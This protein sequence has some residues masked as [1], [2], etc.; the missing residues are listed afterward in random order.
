MDHDGPPV[1][2][3]LVVD[4]A[5]D[6]CV[7]TDG[8][9][10]DGAGFHAFPHAIAGRAHEPAPLDSRAEQRILALRVELAALALVDELTGLH[11]RR[12]FVTLADQHLKVAARAA[13]TVPFLCVDVRGMKTINDTYGRDEGD[14]A[15]VEVAAYLRSALRASDLVARVGGDEFCIVMV[16]LGGGGKIDVERMA[17][18]LRP[19]PVRG[20]R[21]YPLA[22]SIDVAWLEPGPTTSVEE[23]I[24]RAGGATGVV[25]DRPPG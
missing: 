16:D 11:N 13:R 8:S 9:N 22:L 23:W 12:G 21:P 4:A 18:R 15:L 2:E 3:S 17:E 6:A 20:Q 19:G 10:K 25:G 1:G 14:R 7:G 24:G 5:P